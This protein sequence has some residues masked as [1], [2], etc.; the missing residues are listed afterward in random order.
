PALPKE[1]VI[2]Y[3]SVA[4]G[5]LAEVERLLAL[6]PNLLLAN[7]PRDELAV[8]DGEYVGAHDVV[9]LQLERDA[10]CSICTAAMAGLTDR[11]RALLAEDPLRI[12]EHCA[13]NLAVLHYPDF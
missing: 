7:A 4:H 11:V 1:V 12:W 6:Y 3:V 8:D 9:R 10:P 2:P 5:N 13:H